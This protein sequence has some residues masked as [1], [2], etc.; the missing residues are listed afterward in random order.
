METVNIP[1]EATAKRIADALEKHTSLLAAIAAGEGGPVPDTWAEW[2]MVTR[3]GLAG[4]F[5]HP[6]DQ[7]AVEKVKETTAAVKGTGVSGA[8]VDKIKFIKARNEAKAGVYGFE[9]DGAGWR[10]N[11]ELVDLEKM[12][13]TVQGSPAKGDL[14]A[15]TESTNEIVFDVAGVDYDVPAD[16]NY[17]HSITL[18]A[19]DCV[20]SCVF[21][22]PELLWVC[23]KESHPDG[24]PAGTYNIT[25]DHGTYGGG[26]TQDGT[27]QFTTTET[28]PVG[29]GIR[30]SSMGGYQSS[31][32]KDQITSGTIS[33]YGSS[34][35]SL[36]S[37]LAVTE[38][39]E[40]TNLG[41]ASARDMQYVV[42][43][44]W[45]TERQY[46]G[47]NDA[48]V[49]AISQ[50][51]NSDKA[52]GWWKKQ[53]PFD[54]PQTS[55]TAGFL[56]G[57]DPA[58]L[59]VIGDVKKRTGLFKIKSEDPKFFDRN[60]RVWLPSM[61]EVGFGANDGVW[62]TPLVDGEPKQIPL[63]LFKDATNNDRIKYLSGSA[64]WWWLR[65]AHPWSADNVR[66]VSTGGSLNGYGADD[67]HGAV[68]GLCII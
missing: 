42:G 9:F 39:A 6:G 57:L 43:D 24:L 67:S 8:T 26:T 41:T 27:Y 59:A 47:S 5:L 33:T 4:K 54:M 66:Y 51:L 7:F 52:S 29:G 11:G 40:G 63:P 31:Y 55:P 64:R 46:Y 62:E 15:V 2:Q 17:T 20:D 49:S 58:F 35:E 10:E 14:V 50:Y 45:L 22:Q 68:P 28:I 53:H 56:Y 30:H 3:A 61:S 65:G 25:L 18:L 38:G 36:E 48:R 44:C 19:H 60:E 37:K 13:V 34:G 1:R 12:G 32:T 16:P 21:D 23:T